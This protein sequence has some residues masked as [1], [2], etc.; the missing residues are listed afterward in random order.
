MIEDLGYSVFCDTH[1]A[2]FKLSKLL[3]FLFCIFFFTLQS[4]SIRGL[5]SFSQ[6]FASEKPR[7]DLG[8]TTLLCLTQ[9]LQLSSTI[10]ECTLYNGTVCICCL[11]GCFFN[12]PY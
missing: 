5:E 7:L 4:L 3:G 12:Y 2:C 10:S 9:I 11:C 6:S 8:G 1:I